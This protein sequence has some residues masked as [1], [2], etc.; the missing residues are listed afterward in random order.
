MPGPFVPEFK[1]SEVQKMATPK[2]F[3]AEQL[4]DARKKLADLPDLSPNKISQADFV[5]QLKDQIITLAKSKG[6]EASDIKAV[7]G[8][9][10]VKMSAKDVD[11]LL[12]SQRT[13]RAKRGQKRATD[14]Q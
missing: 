10:G 2:T 3:T 7:L 14:E 6:Y 12:A 9:L 8:D 13:P 11:A 5:E 4:E 1:T